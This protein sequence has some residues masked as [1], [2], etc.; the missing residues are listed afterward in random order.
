MDLLVPLVLPNNVNL[1]SS[2]IEVDLRLDGSR[3]SIGKCSALLREMKYMLY[4]LIRSEEM[5]DVENVEYPSDIPLIVT[6]ST[7][8]VR[9]TSI[10]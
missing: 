9:G 2:M 6:R 4:L 5:K 1:L 3:V 8:D 10:E 7:C